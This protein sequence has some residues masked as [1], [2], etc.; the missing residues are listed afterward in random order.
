MNYVPATGKKAITQYQFNTMSTETTNPVLEVLGMTDNDSPLL[1]ILDRGGS[2]YTRDSKLNFK[3]LFKSRHLTTEE[4]ILVGIAC[5]TAT[6]NQKLSVALSEKGRENEI[7]E[8]KIADAV[9]CGSLLT[10]NN[11][12]YRFRH[13][14][15]SD[16][17]DQ[18][19]AGLRM[20][21]MMNPVMGKELFEL[22]SLAVSAMNG[23]ETCIKSH[24]QTVLQSGGNR[25][26]IFE[27][28][29]IASVIKGLS[30]IV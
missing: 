23:C 16:H 12:L 29:R 6:G 21:I 4:S 22:A 15:G 26:R 8:E 18:M 10:T 24:E 5:G 28:I 19:P 2:K 25:D 9:A 27:S 17:Y 11:I 3:S 7:P 30:V 14:V 20:Q 1:D 13:L